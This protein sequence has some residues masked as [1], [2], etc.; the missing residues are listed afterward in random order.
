MQ[1]EK[2]HWALLLFFCRKKVEKN[3]ERRGEVRCIKSSKKTFKKNF[4]GRPLKSNLEFLI[5][6]S[7]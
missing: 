5:F 7:N 3:K 4:V 1:V 2:L 6:L